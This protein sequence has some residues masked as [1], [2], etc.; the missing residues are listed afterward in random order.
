MLPVDRYAYRCGVK[1]MT[2]N[3]T[4]KNVKKSLLC[5]KLFTKYMYTSCQQENRFPF[6]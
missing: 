3:N 1:R 5:T 2:G 6:S 4:S